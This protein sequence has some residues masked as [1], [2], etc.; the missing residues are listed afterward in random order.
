L[1]ERLP[2][3]S[4]PQAIVQ[5]DQF[6]LSPNGKVDVKALPNPVEIRR[7]DQESLVAPRDAVEAELVSLWEKLL[8]VKPIGV[9]ENFF[10]LGGDSLAAIDL[11]L[12]IEKVFQRSL[13]ISVLLEH[14][15]I[16]KLAEI[17]RGDASTQKW[18]SLV[19]IHPMGSLPPLFCIHADGGVMFYYEFARRM[20]K[21]RPI[22]GIQARGLSGEDRPHTNVPQMAS[23]YIAEMRTVQ[24]H[25]PYHFCAFSLGGVAIL[26]MARQLRETGEQVNFVGLL[27][28]YGPGYPQILEDK[29]L[30]DYKMSIHMSNLRMHNWRGKIKYLYYRIEYRLEKI[31]TALL[32]SLFKTL[33]IPLPQTIRYNYVAN[34]LNTIVDNYHPQFC[35]GDVTLFRASTQPENIVADPLL[36]WKDYV[37]KDVKIIEIPGTHNSMI[38][39]PH[40]SILVRAIES[41]LQK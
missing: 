14:P 25:G 11:V 38:K 21:E 3:F 18:S 32:G 35:P 26:E 36:G 29:N 17:L 9:D 40:L 27:D 24:P 31:E 8:Q 6:P 16:S 22:Y 33:R 5:V 10:D 39:D 15:T 37:S 4:L 13:P 7:Q 12:S 34:N 41:E 23:D 2:D 30:V 20:D 28:A 19:P 1:T